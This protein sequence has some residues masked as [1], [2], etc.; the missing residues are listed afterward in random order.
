MLSMRVVPP[1]AKTLSSAATRA[2]TQL[3]AA[4]IPVTSKASR[5]SE[6]M[7]PVGAVCWSWRETV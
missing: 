2:S 3:R 5:A 7:G 6:A 4:R 1:S